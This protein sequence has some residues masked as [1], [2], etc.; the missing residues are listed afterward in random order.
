MLSYR[1]HRVIRNVITARRAIVESV[2]IGAIEVRDVGAVVKAEG[3]PCN[4]E[5]LV[6]M[7]L[8]RKLHVT[9]DGTTMI[10]VAGRV[11]EKAAVWNEWSVLAGIMLVALMSLISMRK[12]PRR[13]VLRFNQARSFRKGRAFFR[14]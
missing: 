4:E 2:R 12:R 5:L 6:G 9:I 14:R 8:L 7:T 1:L 11:P 13:L 3:A 10:L